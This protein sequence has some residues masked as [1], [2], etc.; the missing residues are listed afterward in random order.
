MLT[1]LLAASI[2][3]PEEETLL[4]IY[5]KYFEMFSEKEAVIL[6]PENVNYK[7]NLQLDAKGP[8][9]RPLYPC[10]VKELKHLCIYLEEM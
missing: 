9:Y 8:L 6:P 1:F 5:N 7:I 2:V 10:S 3:E 4:D